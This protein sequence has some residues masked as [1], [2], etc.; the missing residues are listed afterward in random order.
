MKKSLFLI[1]S[2]VVIFSGCSKLS[3]EI[4]TYCGDSPS[5]EYNANGH[6]SYVCS[7]C[8]SDC[9]FCG[10]KATKNFVNISGE[11]TF[12]CNDCYNSISEY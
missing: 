11:M 12:T 9:F 10:D 1:L 7:D 2:L 5:R 8:S 4:C 3:N 6:K